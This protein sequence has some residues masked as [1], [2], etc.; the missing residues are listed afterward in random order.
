LRVETPARRPPAGDRLEV[1]LLVRA[2]VV[3]IVVIDS[4]EI[5]HIKKIVMMLI[6]D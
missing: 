3:V 4:S 6:F 1:R 2:V 5:S